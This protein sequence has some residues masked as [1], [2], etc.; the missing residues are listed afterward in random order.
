MKAALATRPTADLNAQYVALQ[1]SNTR[2]ATN[3]GA[4]SGQT[5]FAQIAIFDGAMLD[6]RVTVTYFCMM[7][8][9]IYF[10]ARMRV[11]APK[12]A[13]VSIFGTIIADI[14]LVIAPLIP[15]FQG[16]IPKTMIIPSAIAIGVGALCNILLF[17]QSTSRIVLQGMQELF[18]Q[19][20]GFGKAMGVHF[21]DPDKR[22]EIKKLLALRNGL[23]ASYKAINDAAKFLPMDFT[24]GK[25]SPEDIGSL[26]ES[27]RQAFVAFGEL[28][29]VPM[30]REHG[31]MKADMLEKLRERSSEQ[32][33]RSDGEIK[34]ATHQI[35]RMIGLHEHMQHLNVNDMT[36]RT[37]ETLS[38]S[39]KVLLPAWREASQHIIE[40]LARRDSKSASQ[41]PGDI[42]RNLT[43]AQSEFERTAGKALLATHSHLFDQHGNVIE[44]GSGR[45][46]PLLGLMIGLLYIERLGNSSKATATLLEKIV[47]LDNARL[48]SRLWLPK[49]LRQLF[50]WALSKDATPGVPG[51]QRTTTA[52]SKSKKQ[53]KKEARKQEA[54]PRD[55]NTAAFYL[56][57]MRKPT[58]RRRHKSSAI[59]LAAIE[60]LT[61]DEGMHALRMLVLTV[62]LGIPAVITTSAGFYYREKG[63]W[64][65]IMAQLS[66]MPYASDFIGGLLTR[67]AGTILGGVIGLACWYIGSG[68]GPGNAYGLATIMAVVIIALMW[69]RLFAPPEQ[70]QATIMT[71]ATIYLVVGY[72]WVDTHIPSY[73]NPGVGYNVFWRRLLLVLIGFG[74]S[75]LVT[76]FPRP[77][78]G[79]RHY[80]HML[81]DEMS[82]IRDRYAL[83]VSTWL[84]SPE[85]LSSVLENEALVSEEILTSIAGPIRLTK[86]E[87]SSSNIDTQTLEYACHLLTILNISITE[88]VIYTQ[89]LSFQQ[90]SKFMHE[91]GCS[92]ES[93]VA[94]LMSVLTLVQH[95]LETGTPLP[96]VLP[97][98]LI[99][100]ALLRHPEAQHDRKKE[101]V[102]DELASESGRHW[103]SAMSAFLRLLSTVD[104]LVLVLKHVVG[105]QNRVDLAVFEH[106]PEKADM[107]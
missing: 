63:L 82:K 17:P 30:Y 42:L 10:F 100:R 98:P 50:A 105:E 58:G 21:R 56:E 85:D 60:W 83:F 76:F 1:A 80:R 88:L 77:P 65:L 5:T 39:L 104:D 90:R 19:T 2:N 3:V 9:F 23:L 36:D 75:T 68:S 97:V 22:F 66:L 73:G 24:Y 12:L 72:S 53:S 8:L 103:I 7:S 78:S 67:L 86:F 13:M 11:S 64:A 91:T 46:P 49:G 71:A 26:Q 54:K 27:F 33:G 93:L 44:D 40:S 57:D 48:K 92:D 101:S 107:L 14:Y 99:G 34:V 102:I 79:N 62:A 38:S 84:T 81:C 16:T 94:D 55:E 6:T 37:F 69:W 18:V 29:Q 32:K 74:A 25:W 15:T 51:L 95:S 59:L 35:A 96:A 45:S 106:D 89:R 61:N 52:A 31:R 28:L 20:N 41:N 47:E 87:F 4:A 70:M 43:E